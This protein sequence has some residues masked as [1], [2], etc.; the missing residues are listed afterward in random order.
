MCLLNTLLD[1]LTWVL[2]RHCVCLFNTCWMY[3]HGCSIGTIDTMEIWNFWICARLGLLA[4]FGCFG[5]KMWIYRK[6][7]RSKRNLT[8]F[9]KNQI[10]P[11]YDGI[12]C[13]LIKIGVMAWNGSKIVSFLLHS[14][15][16]EENGYKMQEIW[17]NWLPTFGHVLTTTHI[18]NL[19]YTS[20]RLMVCIICPVCVHGPLP[21]SWLSWAL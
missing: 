13:I 14:C 3:S 2:N 8:G 12:A 21:D 15:R 16:V 4:W 7:H 6:M 9:L 1:V 20:L 5:T 10:C 11:Y 17:P 18:Y 19:E